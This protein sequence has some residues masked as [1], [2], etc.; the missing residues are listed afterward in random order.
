MALTDKLNAIADAIRE[1]TGKQDQMTLSQMPEE[2]S[3]IAA[4]GGGVTL[5]ELTNPA[6]ATD[7]A[8]DKQL[9][10]PDGNVV[11]GTL[12]EI[13]EGQ[14]LGANQNARLIASG[15]NVYITGET[16]GEGIIR[17][18]ASC[19]IRVP[20]SEFGDAAVEDVA[21]GKT[22]TSAAGL[23]M[24]GT[25]EVGGGAS[26]GSSGI[27][28]GKI[29]LAEYNGTLTI[30]HNLGT[31][32]ILY[33]AAWCESFGDNPTPAGGTICKMWAKTDIPTR[34]GGNGFCTGYGWS[35]TNNYA[36]GNHPNATGY[37]MI[38]ITDENTVVLPR[39]ASGNTSGYY[40]GITY[41]VFVIAANVEV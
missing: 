34:R 37:E 11:T 6:S 24:E 36:D 14:L 22:F 16:T 13:G 18:G 27:Y 29:T 35:A 39:M 40:A 33:A 41:T 21:K 17:P 9:I 1:K 19:R 20:A 3:Q 30:P 38:E 2:I 4:T 7:L 26:D 32:D 8:L 28:M 25:L 23:L 10:G 15:T 12:N 31:T 5:P